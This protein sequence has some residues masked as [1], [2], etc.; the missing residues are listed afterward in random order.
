M[1]KIISLVKSFFKAIS[2]W[3]VC[4]WY[5]LNSKFITE[6]L[7]YL[8]NKLWSIIVDNSSGC[9]KPVEYVMLYEL[10]H[11]WCLYFLQGNNFHPFREVIYY[12]QVEVMSFGCWRA[13][14]SDNIHS[15]HLKWLWRGCWMKMSRCLMDEVTVDLIGMA[16]LSIGDASGIIFDQ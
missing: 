8:A 5:T 4:R 6:P 14:G 10:D 9:T 12:G 15:P 11:I 1:H 13:N 2:S 7:K 3:T 16:S